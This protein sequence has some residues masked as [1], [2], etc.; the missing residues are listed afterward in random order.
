MNLVI[1]IG[2]TLTKV[3]V[4][5]HQEICFNKIYES[6]TLNEV[7]ELMNKYNIVNSIISEVKNFDKELENYLEKHS[8]FIKLN[9][10]TPLPFNNLYITP[11][12]LGK[13]RLA[14]ASA[15]SKLY[16]NSN[17]LVID[18]G[19]CIT[20]DL[21]DENNNYLGGAISPGIELRLKSLSE[22]TGKLPLVKIEK[23]EEINLVGNSTESSI[24]SGVVNGIK[25]E[26]EGVINQ[27]LKQYKELK[28]VLTGGNV[29]RFEIAPK[30]RIFADKF[31]VLRGLNE[32]LKINAEN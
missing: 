11:T 9:N 25:Q 21:I 14:I 13:D 7:K 2:N 18:S 32:I 26:I 17:V 12:T 19:T 15:A 16:S 8:H 20:Y 1:D 3:A 29:E 27:Y 24:K 23:N 30:N 10:Q 4:F 22:F 31:L 6:L 5:S 28:I